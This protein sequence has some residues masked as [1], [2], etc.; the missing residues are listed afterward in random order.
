MSKKTPIM[1]Q[2]ILN[3]TWTMVKKRTN[4]P[5]NFPLIRIYDKQ[6]KQNKHY[7]NETLIVNLNG[8]EYVYPPKAG[9]LLFDYN[10]E[11][12]LLIKNNYAEN[13]DDGKYS[14]PKGH[15]EEH[16]TR[17]ECAEREFYEETGIQ[18]NI[19]DG[20]Q[21]IRV[22]N[23]HYYPFYSDISIVNTLKPIDVDEVS[24]CKFVNLNDIKNLNCNQETINLLTKKLNLVKKHAEYINL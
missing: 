7:E 23:S 11:Y 9:V 17:T 12:V 13:S 6:K 21:S 24:E 15:V 14:V 20:R 16:E 5:F 8:N 3:N 18:I 19:P 4:L 2:K 22:N 10:L 1:G